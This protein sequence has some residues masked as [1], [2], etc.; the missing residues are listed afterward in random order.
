VVSYN[1]FGMASTAA[2]RRLPHCD[3]AGVDLAAGATVAACM[4]TAACAFGFDA[5]RTP[6]LRVLNPA[7]RRLRST[8]G[9]GTCGRDSLEQAA[10]QQCGGRGIVTVRELLELATP[11]AESPME[12]GRGWS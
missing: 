9:S 10:L 7:G 8:D 11:K 5:E 2:V 1:G 6:E 3:C 4:G 12:G